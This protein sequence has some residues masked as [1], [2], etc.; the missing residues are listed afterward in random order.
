GGDVNSVVF[1]RFIPYLHS[2]PVRLMSV[3]KSNARVEQMFAEIAPR[4]DFLNHLLS[5]GV[6][7]YW[8]WRIVRRV[9]FETGGAVLDL[10][11]G[12]GDLALAFYRAGRGRVPIVGADFCRPM[13]AIARGKRERT[14]A[15]NLELIE[16]DAQ[17]LPFPS[18]GFQVVSVAFGL[19]NVSDT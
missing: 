17:Q 11:T 7:K 6:D 10:C 15:A 19:R 9:A 14:S 16:A 5:M 12:T 3:D 18:D 13:L 4:Y 1:F 8:R 2:Y